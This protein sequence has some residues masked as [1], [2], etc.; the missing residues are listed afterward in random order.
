MNLKSQPPHQNKMR[1]TL[2]KMFGSRPKSDMPVATYSRTKH[3]LANPNRSSAPPAFTRSHSMREANTY[4]IPDS[5]FNEP[6]CQTSTQQLRMP[7]Q[8]D[9]DSFRLASRTYQF[10]AAHQS[11][12][13]NFPQARVVDAGQFPGNMELLDGVRKED[14]HFF[15]AMDSEDSSQYIAVNLVIFSAAVPPPPASTCPELQPIVVAQDALAHLLRQWQRGG[16]SDGFLAIVSM[17][18]ESSVHVFRA[19]EGFVEL[20]A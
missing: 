20:P 14:T 5:Y 4:V 17:G 11:L 19:K 6:R 15:V 9:P 8:D 1:N 7:G 16:V 12:M 18:T 10:R 3:P 2:K 13:A